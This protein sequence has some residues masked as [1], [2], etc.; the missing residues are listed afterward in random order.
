MAATRAIR[1]PAIID[2]AGLV[3]RVNVSRSMLVL[4][5]EV[6]RGSRDPRQIMVFLVDFEPGLSP[7]AY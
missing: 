5:G 6:L 3:T 2:Y 4:Y 7:L 1:K